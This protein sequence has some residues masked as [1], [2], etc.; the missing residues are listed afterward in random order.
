MKILNVA[1][2]MP[3]VVIGL[4][5]TLIFTINIYIKKCDFFKMK[6][7]FIQYQ[8]INLTILDTINII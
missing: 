3:L 7:C 5:G 8:I 1:C 6:N 2:S 4:V